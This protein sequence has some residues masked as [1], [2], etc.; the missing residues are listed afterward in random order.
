ME[1]ALA[2]AACLREQPGLDAALTAYE[3]ATHLT[4]LH[5]RYASTKQQPFPHRRFVLS[6]RLQRH[7]GRLR[8]PPGT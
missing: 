2:L 4:P 5:Q 1:D 3:A 8:F 6:A 7:Y